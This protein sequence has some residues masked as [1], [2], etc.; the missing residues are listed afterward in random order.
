MMLFHGSHH[1]GY[2]KYYWFAKEMCNTF[3]LE[4]VNVNINLCK[5]VLNKFGR[6][7]LDCYVFALVSLD[8]D[9]RVVKSE[10]TNPLI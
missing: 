7:N 10:T 4:K 1:F 9:D 5:D 8:F 3:G 6:S 2:D